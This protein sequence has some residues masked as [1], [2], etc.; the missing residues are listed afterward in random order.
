MT[1]RQTHRQNLPIIY[2]LFD[3]SLIEG[4]IDLGVLEVD[5][6]EPLCVEGRPTDEEGDDHSS[7][8]QQDT[9]LV[10]LLSRALAISSV[11]H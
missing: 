7:E 8:K 6:A 2:R 1:N 10:T 9:S 4:A 5:V 3:Y 11:Q